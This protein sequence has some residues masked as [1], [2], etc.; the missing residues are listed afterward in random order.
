MMVLI[1]PVIIIIIIIITIIILY[2]TSP[3]PETIQSN[4]LIAYAATSVSDGVFFTQPNATLTQQSLYIAETSP[5]ELRATL[6]IWQS[7]PTSPR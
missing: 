4:P 1:I 3:H 5:M 7:S 6:I 2:Y